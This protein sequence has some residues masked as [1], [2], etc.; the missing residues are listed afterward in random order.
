MLEEQKILLEEFRRLTPDLN[1]RQQAIRAGID[2]VRYYRIHQG[3]ELKLS[4]YLRLRQAVEKAAPANFNVEKL[5][6]EMRQELSLTV[7]RA[8]LT[9]ELLP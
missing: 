6:S 2:R 9:K 5:G 3:S 1:M 7:N 4:E 8:L